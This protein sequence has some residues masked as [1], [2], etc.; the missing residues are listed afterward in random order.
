[1]SHIMSNRNLVYI[2]LFFLHIC[3]IITVNTVK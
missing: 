2:S 1:M 3:I